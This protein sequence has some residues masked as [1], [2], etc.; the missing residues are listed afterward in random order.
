[1]IK[2]DVKYWYESKDKHWYL[3]ARTGTHQGYWKYTQEEW[4]KFIN[5]AIKEKLERECK[6]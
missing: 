2:L 1:M 4:D 3:S 6:I 5:K